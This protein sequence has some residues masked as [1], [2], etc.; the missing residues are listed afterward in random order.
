[1]RAQGRGTGC[2]HAAVVGR[3]SMRQ[4]GAW[5]GVQPRLRGMERIDAL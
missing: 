5:H 2:D 4:V 3:G 1:M